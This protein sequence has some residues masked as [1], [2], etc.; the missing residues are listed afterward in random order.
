M[1]TYTALIQVPGIYINVRG[2]V[3]EDLEQGTVEYEFI[4]ES[5]E[6]L[7]NPGHWAFRTLNYE[8]AELFYGDRNNLNLKFAIKS[9]IDDVDEFCDWLDNKIPHDWHV[10]S[11][12]EPDDIRRSIA[13]SISVWSSSTSHNERYRIQI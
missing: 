6:L 9:D 2:R 7:T 1:K 3:D 12:E 5:V 11:V 10:D 13:Q 4:Q 8:V